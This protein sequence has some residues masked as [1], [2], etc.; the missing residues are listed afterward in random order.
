M[1]NNTTGEVWKDAKGYEGLYLVSNQGRVK[2][3]RFNR[4]MKPGFNK[5]NGYLSVR[6]SKDKKAES[7]Y[8]H[9]LVASAFCE[10]QEEKTEVN[11]KDEV[12][13]NNYASN[14][15][16][17]TRL[18]NNNYNGRSKR[19]AKKVSLINIESGHYER[20]AEM[21]SK[22]VR[23][24]DR[25]TGEWT[26]YNSFTQAEKMNVGF[27]RANISRAARGKQGH[28]HGYYWELI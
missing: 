24:I 11:H 3:L 8:V 22:G 23:K 26:D 6:L 12:K 9:R 15:E 13:T 21:K 18:E 19:I 2:S 1:N 4:V 16:W 25:T 7:N 10:R 14:L 28:A 27:D 20:L 5:A 17:V